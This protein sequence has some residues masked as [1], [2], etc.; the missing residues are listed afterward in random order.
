MSKFNYK[1]SALITVAVLLLIGFAIAGSVLNIIKIVQ[2]TG[3]ALKALGYCIALAICLLTLVCAM[4][5]MFF[6]SYTVNS[7]YVTIRYGI[8]YEKIKLAAI[9]GV[10]VFK[11]TD[12]LVIYY[13]NNK[14]Q[15]ILTDVENYDNFINALLEANPD[16][17]Y[18]VRHTD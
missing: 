12:A 9:T 7:D 13:G 1:K 8:F 6:S 17:A 18:D 10:T 11:K 16:V 15:V 2:S 14:Y 5:V 3:D 4:G